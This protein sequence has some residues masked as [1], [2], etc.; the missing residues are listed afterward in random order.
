MRHRVRLASR[1]PALIEPVSDVLARG[2]L[3]RRCAAESGE[4]GV[5]GQP[6]GLVAHSDEQ[7]RH[8]TGDNAEPVTQRRIGMGGV[9][10]AI[11]G[12]LVVDHA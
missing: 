7:D 3:D 8:D 2:C 1:L 5:G 11:E 12:A 10:T 9:D 6:F 4:G